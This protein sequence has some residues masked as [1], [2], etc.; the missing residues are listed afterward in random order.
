MFSLSGSLQLLQNKRGEFLQKRNGLGVPRNGIAETAV[1]DNR[2]AQ[3]RDVS[4]H[5]KAVPCC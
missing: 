5:M 4:G 1:Q 2:A 3:D